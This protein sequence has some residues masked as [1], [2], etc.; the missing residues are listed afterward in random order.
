MLAVR[1]ANREGG[2]A[3]VPRLGCTGLLLAGVCCW[4]G[5]EEEQVRGGSVKGGLRRAA[6]LW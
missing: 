3:L 2:D 1:L 5:S 4:D 6:V